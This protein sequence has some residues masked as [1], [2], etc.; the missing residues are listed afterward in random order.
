MF[1][2]AFA[3]CATLVGTLFHLDRG[4]SIK[5]SK[6]LW[7]PVIWLWIVGSRPVSAWLA[8]WFG[9][10]GNSGGLDAQLDGNPIDALIFLL[11]LISAIIVLGRR[12]AKT[13]A[14]LSSSLPILIYFAF[15]LISC[16]WSPF[17][18]VAL[19][20]W[21]KAVGD[22]AMV[23]VV[24][25]DPQPVEALR[26]L[27][28]RVGLILLPASL[29]LIRYSALG[30]GFDE[31][32]NPSN[33]G[34][35]TNKNMLGLMAWVLFLGAVWSL[36]SV[37]RTK[38]NPTRRRR[39]VVYLAL[40]GFGFGVLAVAHSAT[41][42]SCAA[43]GCGLMLLSS[44]SWVRRRPARLNVLASVLAV[45]V[46][47]GMAFDLKAV[48]LQSLGRKPDL[49]GRTAIWEMII[50]MARNPI[51]GAGYESFW[52]ASAA[53]LHRIPGPE[54]RMFHQLNTAHN[55]YIDTYLNLGWVGV[56]L[57]GLILLSGYTRVSGAFQRDQEVG[58][59]ALMFLIPSAVY[60]V[61]E[62]GFRLLTP[63]WISLLLAVVAAGGLSKGG[64]R[65][66][67]SALIHSTYLR[68]KFRSQAAWNSPSSH[69]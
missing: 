68:P 10:G 66:Q 65:M 56:S 36:R 4:K 15:C 28:S 62:A 35:T 33:L 64:L 43:L 47:L 40:V 69:E 18:A 14:Y 1:W 11:L 52:N 25:T 53:E 45:S 26:K 2:L 58:A 24:L 38:K 37:Y 46:A 39:L 20:R 51:I 23:L 49:T 44:L 41:S 12:K 31:D 30:R 3:L 55:G 9:I 21:V 34:V 60:S 29:L 54:G 42:I 63:S 57:I 61:T 5:T 7:L 32:G 16:L 8:A 48:V 22:L 50:P 59:L 17:T 6:A 67:A 13:K 27:F 19:K